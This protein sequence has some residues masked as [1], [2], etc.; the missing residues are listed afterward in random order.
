MLK[1]FPL[2]RLVNRVHLLWAAHYSRVTGKPAASGVSYTIFDSITELPS[3][4]WDQA[5]EKNDIF[6]STLYLQAL[7]QAPPHNMSFRYAI[8]R[9]K[10]NIIGIVYFQILQMDYHIHLSIMRMLKID[11]RLA[12]PEKESKDAEKT[13]IRLLV[14]GNAMLSGEHGFYMRNLSFERSMQ[15]IAEIAYDVR[16][17]FPHHVAITLVKDFYR[18]HDKPG[19]PL[20]PFGFSSFDAGPNMIVPIRPNWRAFNDYLNEMKPKYR[21]RAESA[22]KKGKPIER[23]S[24]SL[25]D[26]IQYKKDLYDL[27]SRVAENAKFKIYTVV[28]EYFIE[29][30]RKLGEKFE[31]VGL[32]LNNDLIGFTTRIFNDNSMEG[33]IHGIK[34]E[35]NKRYEL[36]QNILLDDIRAAITAR[37][38]EINTGRTSIAMKSSIGAVP[39]NMDCYMR[40]SGKISNHFFSHIMYFIKPST[41]QA[42]DPFK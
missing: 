31:C 30:K 2:S 36:Y 33:Y 17:S 42:R 9:D 4:I 15:V 14:C 13:R 16:T 18:K 5:N 11:K 40:F 28:P 29:L 32:F 38:S 35:C 39:N 19:K 20:R 24:L 3:T 7:E 34:Y 37:V 26:I 10:G 12:K 41:E 23:R 22:L 8:V 27:Y 6:L 25:D 21:K 1:L